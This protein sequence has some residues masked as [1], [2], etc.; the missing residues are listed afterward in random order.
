MQEVGCFE[1]NPLVPCLAWPYPLQKSH[2]VLGWG[3]SGEK[4]SDSKFMLYL[5]KYSGGFK[6]TPLCRHCVKGSMSTVVGEDGWQEQFL[7]SPF[8]GSFFF[9]KI[10]T[11]Y[12]SIWT[13]KISL[14]TQWNEFHS[15]VY[16]Y[17][18]YIYKYLKPVTDSLLELVR[19]QKP[20]VKSINLSYSG[21]Q[22]NPCGT[23]IQN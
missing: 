8:D 19:M 7:K 14:F 18:F 16:K 10:N 15:G 9:V 11:F 22:N 2:F 3:D 13:G 17:A 6:A 12:R 23:N 1:A 4:C 20:L 21:S 5:P